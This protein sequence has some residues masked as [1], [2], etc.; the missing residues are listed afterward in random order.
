MNFLTVKDAGEKWG[1]G[2]RMV[3]F[4]C[5]DGRIAG[6]VKRGNLWLIPEHAERPA[7]KRCR[8]TKLPQQSLSSDLAAVLAATTV[9]MP[10]DHPD[11]IL[12]IVTDRRLQLQYEGE[13]AYS[14]G[15]FGRTLDCFHE[16]EGD[17]AA[18]LRLG[19][20]AVA[21]AI[22]TGDYRAYT[23]IESD[24]RRCAEA[25]KGSSI[26]ALAE[27]SPATAAV[28]CMAPNMA[29]EWLKSGDLRLLPRQLRPYALYLRA[30]YLQCTGRHE[31]ML[32]VAQTALALGEPEG[33]LTLNGIYLRLCCA[34]ACHALEREDEARR[35]LLEAMHLA[36][37]H[38]FITP[39]A[40]N[41]TT[42]G[43]MV[44]QCILQEFPDLYGAV[45]EQWERTFQNWTGFHNQFTKDN[46]TLVLSRREY[47]IAQM[48][49]RRIPYAK[50]AQ[51]QCI[52]VGR[53]KNIV[54]EIYEKLFISSRAEL[55]KYVF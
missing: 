51:Q 25:H 23:E 14:R 13:L 37:P 7:D 19:P 8:E 45:L 36:L 30:K 50:I 48:V 22:S 9:P 29:P 52:S 11:S 40:E 35:Y 49:A 53:L 28:S 38:G 55:A 17:E 34:A 47:H 3:T 41:V 39:F 6:A 4:Y 27:L 5:A 10:I 32:A 15:D 24:L 16:T 12:N 54:L 43:G 46:L 1:L 20:A 42:L 26:A 18:R 2:T 44:E 21:A 31:A 33:E